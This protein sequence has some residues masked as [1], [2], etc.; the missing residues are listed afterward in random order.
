MAGHHKQQLS[1]VRKGGEGRLEVVLDEAVGGG[2]C[3]CRCRPSEKTWPEM[4][5]KRCCLCE[6]RSGTWWALLCEGVAV[7]SVSTTWRASVVGAAGLGVHGLQRP[8]KLQFQIYPYPLT[9]SHRASS[10]R[11]Q[12]NASDE[13]SPIDRSPR[14]AGWC[15]DGASLDKEIQFFW[16]P[17]RRGG[18]KS[19][20]SLLA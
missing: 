2:R 13:G 3:R 18:S 10:A 20:R 19:C 11:Q 16:L 12:G 15:V 8:Q 5:Q 6:K 4:G 7:C 9:K 1:S 17:P 14:P